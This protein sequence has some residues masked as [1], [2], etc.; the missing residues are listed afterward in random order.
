M[1]TALVLAFLIVFGCVCC[2]GS[3]S[4]EGWKVDLIGNFNL[5]QASFSNWSQGGE[6]TL[7]WQ[8]GFDGAFTYLRGQSEIANKFKLRYGMTKTGDAEARKSIDEISLASIY[9]YRAGLFVDPYIGLNAV[10]QISKGYDYAEASKTAISDFMDPVYLMQ[11]AGLG[12]RCGEIFRSRLGFA[13]KETMT[14]DFPTY[15]DDPSTPETEKARVEI[16]AELAGD[17]HL[18]LTERILLS[19]SL[20]AFSNFKTTREIDV[21]WDTTL[22]AKVESYLAVTFNLKM[23]Y[24]RDVSKKRQI[25]Q[26]LAVGLTY[27]FM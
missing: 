24:D 9:T 2:H 11:S 4:S 12:H 7:G 22:T 23:I 20:L 26:G 19:S 15:S 3:Q 10:T 5:T 27:A 6:N 21:T 17:L 1:K 25:K 8:I 14:K 16:G 18:E 13:L